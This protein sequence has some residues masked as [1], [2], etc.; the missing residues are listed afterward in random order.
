MIDE[1]FQ[2][3]KEAALLIADIIVRESPSSD[4]ELQS[5]ELSILTAKATAKAFSL[6]PILASSEVLLLESQQLS[7]RK[8]KRTGAV[9]NYIY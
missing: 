5:K 1:K 9:F 8:Y 2:S 3:E 7:H 4:E 6:S